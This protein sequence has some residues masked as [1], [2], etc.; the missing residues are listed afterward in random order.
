MSNKKISLYD[1]NDLIDVSD[2]YDED[3][4]SEHE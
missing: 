4:D 2:Y 3:Y 1:A